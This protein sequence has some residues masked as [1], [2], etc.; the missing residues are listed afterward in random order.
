MR[1]QIFT[2]QG[3]CFVGSR[4]RC[5]PFSF[6]AC[7]IRT[8]HRIRTYIIGVCLT[9][10]VRG[11]RRGYA[12]LGALD[13]SECA[14]HFV[15]KAEVLHFIATDLLSYFSNNASLQIPCIFRP[16]FPGRLLVLQKTTAHT[17]F[18]RP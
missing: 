12:G 8:I 2:V 11:E 7:G 18:E 16:V 15:A 14:K 5:Y 1:D 3:G 10:R 17:G 13:R 4:V 9:Q 6:S